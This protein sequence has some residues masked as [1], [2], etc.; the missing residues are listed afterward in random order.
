MTREN[1]EDIVTGFVWCCK[2]EVVRR[3]DGGQVRRVLSDGASRI[4]EILVLVDT[5]ISKD[6]VKKEEGR[7]IL[8]TA[9][10]EEGN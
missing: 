1:G 9:A 4:V 6:Q 5:E 8:R 2:D 10:D 7:K 3:N